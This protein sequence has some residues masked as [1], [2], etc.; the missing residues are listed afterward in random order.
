MLNQFELALQNGLHG[1]LSPMVVQQQDTTKRSTPPPHAMDRSDTRNNRPI[2][3]LIHED[4]ACPRSLFK[5]MSMPTMFSET[6]IPSSPS[7]SSFACKICIALHKTSIDHYTP[8]CR[9][10]ICTICE[11]MQASHFPEDCPERHAWLKGLQ[12]YEGDCVMIGS[13]CICYHTFIFFFLFLFP[14]IWLRIH[15]QLG[16]CMGNP[17]VFQRNPYLYPW[18]PIPDH[19]QKRAYV[20]H[21]RGWGG[22]DDAKEW[23]PSK[24]SICGSFSR[25]MWWL[26][27]GRQWWWC[28][29]C[30]QHIIWGWWW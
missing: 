17:G 2:Q 13:V 28:I 5:R 12:S 15:A 21:F 30:L 24:T 6:T 20:A 22:G 26:A 8:D 3:S 27:D 10:Y 16:N 4:C 11:K 14:S 7:D 25:V 9:Q 29:A 23:S 1:R 19:P 18:K